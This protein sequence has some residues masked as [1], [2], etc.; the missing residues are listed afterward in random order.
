MNENNL[1]L[2]PHLTYDFSLNSQM[3]DQLVVQSIIKDM[4]RPNIEREL[5]ES[6]KKS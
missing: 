6:M 1:I 4:C 5:N 2:T 3:Y